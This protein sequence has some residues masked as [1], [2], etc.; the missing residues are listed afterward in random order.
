MKKLFWIVLGIAIIGYF[1]FPDLGVRSNNT[2]TESI[3]EDYSKTWTS[4]SSEQ[5]SV[6]GKILQKNNISGC[7]QYYIKEKLSDNSE[8]TVACTSDGENF[9]YYLLWKHSEKVIPITDDGLT[10]PNL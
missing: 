1:L 4:P 7:G 8:L 2:N 9:K 10:K 3:S 5:L 6:I